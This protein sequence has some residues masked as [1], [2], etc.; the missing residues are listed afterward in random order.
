[1]IQRARDGKPCLEFGS[2]L[3]PATVHACQCL[4]LPLSCHTRPLS[5]RHLRAKGSRLAPASQMNRSSVFVLP[6][7]RWELGCPEACY[8]R[9]DTESR[10]HSGGDVEAQ[11]VPRE[12]NREELEDQSGELPPKGITGRP[13]CVLNPTLLTHLFPPWLWF[14]RLTQKRTVKV[15]ST[16]SGQGLFANVTLVFWHKFRFK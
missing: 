5:R 16:Q 7:L 10:V 13:R 2:S 4:V 12:C 3:L 8:T 14:L 9:G 6:S 1:M 15:S 11:D